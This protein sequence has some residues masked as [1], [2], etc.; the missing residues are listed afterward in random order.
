MCWLMFGH[1]DSTARAEDSPP[2]SPE[3]TGFTLQQLVNV[4]VTSVSK[5]PESLSKAAAAITVISQDDI[6]RSGARTI[7]EALR[8]SPGLAVAQVD[9]HTWAISSRGFNDSFANKLLVLM[10]GR[11]VY[12]PLFSGVYWDAQD[13]MMEDIERIEVIRGPG[14]T[15]WGANAVNGV[16][17]IITRSAKETQGGLVVA[18]AGNE[19]LGFG[20]LRYGGRL[21][22]KA[23]YRVYSKYDARDESATAS[24]GD[25]HDRWQMARS[26]F[27]VDWEA[28]ENSRL[29]FQ[30]DVYGGR[31]D[32][33]YELPTLTPPDF[34]D[35]GVHQTDVN[36]ANLLGR[37]KQDFSAES[38]MTLQMYYD[39]TS[40][41]IE[42]VLSEHR[43]TIDVD[44]QNHWTLNERNHWIWGL[45]YRVGVDHL[46]GSFLTSFAKERRTSQLISLFAQ[47]EIELVRDRLHAVL[48]SKF[49]YNDYT[50]F[51]VQPG[52]RLSWTP[53]DR[54]TIWASV[55]RAV[56]TP[57]RAEDGIRLNQSVFP[58]APPTVVS[59]FGTSGYESEELL[60][61]EAGYRV[62]LLENLSIDLATFYNVYDD[63]RTTEQRGVGPD[64]SLPGSPTVVRLDIENRATGETYGGELAMNWRVRDWWRLRGSYSLLETQ[65]HPAPG[66][67]DSDAED[68]EGKS[69]HHQFVL[70]SSLDLPGHVHFDML[71]R[72]VDR[73]KEIG[74]D[75]YFAL[76]LRLAWRPK[77]NLELSI[78]GQ[79]LF[80]DRHPEFVPTIIPIQ[81]TE[82]QR[83]IY[84]KVS[85]GF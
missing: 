12:T 21:G 33:L 31:E 37:W 24:G 51:E 85:F 1:G 26:G 23:H 27:R 45:G 7:A 13:T 9:S 59:V 18:G 30:G 64:P 60:A 8:L 25:A 10:D 41:D 28:T 20:A 46:D 11:S 39:R 36:G 22:E 50:G 73:L 35:V 81:R 72:Y 53:D 5:R 54:Q 15:L 79:N 83:S 4:Q 71:G 49:E 6:Q 29:T 32:Q 16:I 52:L 78:V 57:S 65:I 3:L 48:G 2:A 63:L 58:G 66:S 75:A 44:W 62:Q 43:D 70:Q 55:T 56:R 34:M 14:A 68:D 17:N 42:G 82:T 40:R 67:S 84:G 47:D 80:E 69:P 61:Y 77:P 19:E 38:D 74:V 76:D